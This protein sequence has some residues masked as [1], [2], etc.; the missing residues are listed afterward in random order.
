MENVAKK[1]KV[2]FQ[3][4]EMHYEIEKGD[5]NKVLG[6]K[7]REREQRKLIKIENYM[8]ENNLLFSNEFLEFTSCQKSHIRIPFIEYICL[9]R[10]WIYDDEY[11]KIIM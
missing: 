6:R 1:R 8:R 11:L 5:Y 9:N 4:Y 10:S 7:H 3:K 2:R